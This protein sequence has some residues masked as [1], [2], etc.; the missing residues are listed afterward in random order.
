MNSEGEDLSA[1]LLLA[2]ALEPYL[3]HLVFVGGWAHR[4]YSRRPEARPLSFSPLTTE[5][6]DII[7]PSSIPSTLP[8]ISDLLKAHDF[9]VKMLGTESPPVTRYVLGR[10]TDRGAFY[11][12]FLAPL[13]GPEYSR[14]GKS[15]STANRAGVSLQQLRN[16]EL[17]LVNPWTVHPSASDPNCEVRIANAMAFLAQKLLIHA[18]S[19]VKHRSPREILY[20]HDTLLMFSDRLDLLLSEWPAIEACLKPRQQRNIEEAHGEMFGRVTDDIR[21]AAEIAKGT[22]RPNPPSAA[23]ILA[24][25]QA[26]LARFPFAKRRGGG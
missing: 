1:F 22:A 20:I 2:K 5:D 19:K 11:A 14:S 12:E 21:Q 6:A 17:L 25:C 9:Q 26:G 8:S 4:L 18:D 10:P 3:E 13:T 7:L 16:V 24:V 15:R 23:D